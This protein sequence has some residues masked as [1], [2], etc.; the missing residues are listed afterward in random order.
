MDLANLLCL[1]VAFGLA[2]SLWLPERRAKR[3]VTLRITALSYP[4][5]PKRIMTTN[6]RSPVLQ[7]AQ[8]ELVPVNAGGT[9][10][11]LDADAIVAEVVN[12][13]PGARTSVQVL[14]DT[15]GDRRFLVSLIPGDEPGE[16][17]FR[18][19]GDAQPGEGVEILEEEFIYTATPDNA[20]SLG[21]TVSYLPKTSLPA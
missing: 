12:G 3:R 9:K 17:T 5:K 14:D 13:T 10:V 6:L 19:R 1:L 20:V 2:L 21:V 18:I 15:N 4:P 7:F 8:I 11:K 16:N